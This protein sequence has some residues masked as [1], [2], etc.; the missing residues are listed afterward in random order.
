MLEETK[1]RINEHFKITLGMSYDE[2][3]ELDTDDQQRLIKEYHKKHPVK[4]SDTEIVMIGSGE[5]ALFLRKKKG[6]RILITSGDHS[7]ITRVGETSE[8]QEKR[9]NEY[10]DRRKEG[11]IKQLIKRM[12]G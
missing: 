7:I 12:R 8:S 1:K 4:K 11:K 10:F 2:F 9:F 6:E 5:N 3:K